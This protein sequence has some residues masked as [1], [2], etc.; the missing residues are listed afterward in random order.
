MINAA[1]K[2][3]IILPAIFTMLFNFISIMATQRK[4]IA[5]FSQPSGGLDGVIETFLNID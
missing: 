3:I 5:A 2:D 1:I 4:A